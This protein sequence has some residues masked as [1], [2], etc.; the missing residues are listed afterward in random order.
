MLKCHI[1]ILYLHKRVGIWKLSFCLPFIQT[2]T[3]AT[4]H[5]DEMT[6]QQHKD[7]ENLYRLNII[8]PVDMTKKWLYFNKVMEYYNIVVGIERYDICSVC[9]CVCVGV[10][11]GGR[12]V[13][14]KFNFVYVSLRKNICFEK[15]LGGCGVVL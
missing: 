10:C 8:K 15:K 5:V 11:P 14:L 7:L 6:F 12:G 4:P 1:K 9:G 3:Q 13:S 2:G